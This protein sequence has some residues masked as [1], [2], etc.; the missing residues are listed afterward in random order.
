MQIERVLISDLTTDPNNVRLHAAESIDGIASS[1]RKW[2]QQKPIVVDGTGRI[3]SGN[4]TLEAARKM[5]WTEIDVVRTSLQ[6]HEAVAF[7]IADN[8]TAELS[9]WDWGA[10]SAVLDQLALAEEGFPDAVGFDRKSISRMAAYMANVDAPSSNQEIDEG[11]LSET[12]HECP[13]CKFKW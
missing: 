2:G 8:R 3:V 11:Q 7:A 13:S 12:T 9:E 6:G 5:G 10:L 4:G 1:L